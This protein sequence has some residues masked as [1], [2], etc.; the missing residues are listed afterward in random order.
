MTNKLF[1]LTGKVSLITGGASFLGSSM[2]E[3]LVDAG[4]EVI[5]VGRDKIK[6]DNQA[7]RINKKSNRVS[8]FC[9]D[10][11][12]KDKVVHLRNLIEKEYGKL[13]ILINSA[14]YDPSGPNDLGALPEA[15]LGAADIALASPWNLIQENLSLLKKDKSSKCPASIIN[16]T[17]MYGKVSP[18]P[19]VYKKTNQKPNP[20]Y[21]GAAKAGL[22][23]LTKW[24][25]CNL[26]E[27]FIRVNSISF[28]AFPDEMT[29]T[30]HPNFI[31][32]LERKIPLGRIGHPDEVRGPL[33][34][35]ASNA[36]SYITGADISVD[37]GWT[38]W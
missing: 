7:S 29:Q 10:I 38:A 6:L 17:S 25:A 32:E 22:I 27:H 9:I 26:S 16:I 19:Y 37:G 34:F 13:D 31:S 21:Y 30:N 14:S 36:S 3:A 12:V 35:L 20:P 15:F 33:V 11:T 18:Y 8:T 5:M 24:M 28:G 1:D 4:S 2:T 23:Q